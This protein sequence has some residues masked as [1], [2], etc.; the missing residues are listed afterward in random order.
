MFDYVIVGAGSAGCVLANRLS[1]DPRAKVLLLE[2][3]GHDRSRRVQTPGL[4]G[5]LWRNRFDWAFFTEPQEH[6]VGRRM[7]WPRGKVLGGCSS[8][9][10]MVYMRGHRDNYDEWRDLGNEGWGYDDVLPCFK[11]SENNARDADAFHG[12][13]GPLDVADP[14]GNPMTDLL[15]DAARDALGAPAN[16]D[17]NG[18]HQEGFGRFQ[19]TIRGGARCSSAVAF[20]RPAMS[21]SNLTVETDALVLGVVVEK[22][23]AV[24]VRYRKDGKTTVAR[25]DREVIVSAG[26]VGS[27]HVLLLS[28]I[29]PADDL[30]AKGVDVVADLPGVGKNLQ[31]HLIVALGFEDRAGITG[32]VSPLN[33]LKWLA[34]YAINQKGP[35]ASNVAEGGGFVRTRPD[36]KRPDLQF[37]FMPVGSSQVSF[38]DQA[39]MAKGHAF[40]LVPTLLYPKSRGEIGLDTRD[41]SKAPRIDPRYFSDPDDLRVLVDGVVLAQTIAGSRLLDH[42]RGKCLTPLCDTEDRGRIAEE[43]RKRCNTLFHPVG[44]CKMG[45]DPM[46]VVDD[47]LR[48]RGIEGLR[49]ADASIMPTIVGGNTNA[50]TIMIGER[51]ADLV[52][53]VSPQK[54]SGARTR[55]AVPDS[56]AAR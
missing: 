41:P 39:F 6:L 23:R 40:S 38:D 44:T 47:K 50:P 51:A 29:G 2:A 3:G 54:S 22:G 27:P 25:A 26:A 21:R 56:V 18:A 52:L 15:I 28:G 16:R 53:G 13:G 46:A 24:G 19:A 34:Q 43:I 9:N 4:M 33:L 5:L 11:R 55:E 10:Y 36:E 30:R 37:H 49:V 14:A 45:R 17:F 31:D 8:I 35:L 48:V 42:A 20:L 7:H 1:A 32:D 12:V